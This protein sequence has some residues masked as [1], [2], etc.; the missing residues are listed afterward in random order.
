MDLTPETPQTGKPSASGPNAAGIRW[1]LGSIYPSI[2]DARAALTKVGKQAQQFE[3]A[4]RGKV[5]GLSGT[6]LA[7]ALKDLGELQNAQSRLNEYALLRLA[8]DSAS[9]ENRDLSDAVDKASIAAANRSRFFEL[10]WQALPEA[11]ARRRAAAPEVSRDRHMLERLTADAAHRLSEPEERVLSE[12][13]PS[14]E[15]AWQ[16]LFRQ[17]LSTIE[18][19]FDDG[20]GRRNRTLDEML[21]LSRDDRRDVRVAAL[22]AVYAA[23]APW[24]PV[25]AKSYDSLVGDRLTLDALRHY[26]SP[27]QQAN[28][29]NDLPDAVV[30]QLITSVEDHY[31]LAQRWFRTKAKLMGLPKLAL[32]DQYASLG[33]TRQVPFNDG[34]AIL[35][36][37]I[38]RFSP[39]VWSILKA[40][41][42]EHRIDAEPRS[43]K[44][45]G[46]FCAPVAQDAKPVLLMNYT[47]TLRDVETLAHELGHLLHFTLAAQA[48]T[49][50][51]YETGMAMAEIASTFNEMLIFDLLLAEEKDPKVRQALIAERIESS[52]ATVFRQ[53]M[54]ARYEQRA[55]AAKADD[56]SLTPERLSDI[57]F[58]ENQ[59]YYGDSIELPDG[60]KLGWAYIP[61]FINTRF[62]TYS[63]SFAH[64]A[65][66]ALY[67]KYRSEG[68]PFVAKYLG[69]LAAGGSKTPQDLLGAM[70]I[71]ISDPH[72]VDAGFG[73]IER[74]VTLAETA[75]GKGQ[76]A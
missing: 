26:T 35:R 72:W 21:S 54:M 25:L 53:T 65:S 73:E 19:P 49:P 45:G 20:S 71:D 11:E 9:S 27:M 24:A 22:E 13:D 64:L 30:D 23:L 66:L 39:K 15:G 6:A 44:E 1:D 67:A 70:G 34:V 18:I 68:S 36:R 10:E 46:A 14:A 74:M 61:H 47:D 17:T 5:A 57:W 7:R 33:Q 37:A 28:F 42:D 8:A 31:P 38:E 63:Y 51:G 75:P 52:F 58:T 29:D 43:G 3:S 4:Y 60:Y 48:Q 69:F 56:Q 50:H 41:L 40:A 16:Q 2:A 55:Y 59:R 76:A 12:R 62:Y 32:A